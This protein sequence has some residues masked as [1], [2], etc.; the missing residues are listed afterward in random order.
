L[1]NGF[2]ENKVFCAATTI[3]SLQLSVRRSTEND[4]IFNCDFILAWRSIENDSLFPLFSVFVMGLLSQIFF[5][6]MGKG[7]SP[8]RRTG[9][10]AMD[11]FFQSAILPCNNIRTINEEKIDSIEKEQFCSI[12]L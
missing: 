8:I 12:C 3:R 6:A 7:K 4:L 2:D 1:Q 5:T 9:N 10:V 11:N